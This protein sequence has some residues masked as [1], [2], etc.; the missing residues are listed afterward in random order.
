MDPQ[1]ILRCHVQLGDVAIP[2]T[3]RPERMAESI[4]VFDVELSESE[5]A[6][7]DPSDVVTVSGAH[8]SRT[9]FPMVS[10]FEGVGVVERT[11][12][13][14]AAEMIGRCVLPLGSAAGWARY[15]R[16]DASRSV[17]VPDDL[18]DEAACFAVA[19]R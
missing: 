13:C 2:K 7:I 16:V 6:A 4:A 17:P 18:S 3:S 11:G 14:V 9:L 15:E 10:R 1:I 5:T 19:T 12:H 8:V